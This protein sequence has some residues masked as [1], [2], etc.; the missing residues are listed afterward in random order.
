MVTRCFMRRHGS[1]VK[2]GVLRP[3][4]QP[5]E[6]MGQVKIEALLGKPIED[7]P[8]RSMFN[9]VSTECAYLSSFDPKT[10]G[11]RFHGFS[12]NIEN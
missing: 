8:S 4:Q 9:S 2:V 1:K 6:D 11:H 10:L 12:N 7:F 5:V 3:V